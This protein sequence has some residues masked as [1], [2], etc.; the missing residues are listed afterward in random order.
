[1]KYNRRS[2]LKLAGAATFTLV[3]GFAGASNYLVNGH[4]ASAEGG[5]KILREGGNAIDAIVAA[6]STAAILSPNN[7]GIG[8]YGGHMVIARENGKRVTAIDFN[9][10]APSAATPGMFSGKDRTNQFGWLA[11]GVPGT[12]AGLQMAL[13][14]Y[15]TKPLRELI[16]PAIQF[17]EEG[18]SIPAGVAGAIK[19]VAARLKKDPASERLYFKNGEPLREGDILRNPDLAKL[20]RELARENSVEPF[21]RGEISKRIAREFEK[22]GGLVTA[23]DMAN[24][25]AREVEPL[26]IDWNGHTIFTVPLTAGGVSILQGLSILKALQWNGEKSHAL[27]E[28]LR[29]AW[30][31][32]LT[33]LGDPE[34][35]QDPTPRLLS[36]DHIASLAAEVRD[37][38]ENEKALEIKSNRQ[39]HGGTIHLNAIDAKGNAVALTLTHGNAFGACVTVEGLGLTLG[40]GMSRFETNPKHP[41]APGPGK[42]PLTN[43]CPTIVLHKGRTIAALGGTGGRLIPN[44]LYNILAN[45]VGAGATMDQAIA[46]PR[47]GTDGSL[48]LSLEKTWPAEDAAYLQQIGFK[49]KTAPSAN[50]HAIA[51]GPTAPTAHSR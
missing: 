35:I 44:A 31:D 18:F 3:Q 20:L 51:I 30:R 37:A 10:I 42:R 21:Y 41:N 19:G 43:M 27:I 23:N 28:A 9:T 32:R 16:A 40:H 7:C 15:G 13:D 29:L 1:M 50:A 39:N 24:F 33:T 36:K 45:F 38:V 12:L 48:D 47:P 11:S 14:R 8:S 26:K 2:A 17:A 46:A 22:H 34:K 25:K 5:L 6:A 4:P 49:T